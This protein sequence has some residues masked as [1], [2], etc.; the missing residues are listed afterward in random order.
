MENIKTHKFW[1]RI[2]KNA[3]IL[4]KY[5]F[6]FARSSSDKLAKTFFPFDTK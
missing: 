5:L 6:E 3:K 2:L 4:F 1:A